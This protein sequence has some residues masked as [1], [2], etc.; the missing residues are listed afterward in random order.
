MRWRVSTSCLIVAVSF[1][2]CGNATAQ[3]I[4]KAQRVSPQEFA[5]LSWGPT[6]AD[7]QQLEW[8][9]DAG[10]NVAGFAQVKDLPVFEKAGL[11]VFVSDKRANG[12]DFEKPLDDA[13]VRRNL[14]SLAKEIGGSPAVLGLMLQDEPHARA[15]PSLGL[16]ARLMREY[17]PGKWPY[18]N[19]FPVRV[20]ADRMGTPTYQ[21]YVRLLV[22][23]IRQPFLSYDN[24][25][26]IGGQMGEAF[27]QNL[28]VVR[29][30]A[31]E[32]GAPL[33]NCVLSNA[34]FNYMENTDATYS[35]QAW[36]TMAH[37]ARGI[38]YFSYFTWSNGNY[39]LGPIDQFG[40][41]TPS[42]DMMRRVNNQIHALAPTLAKLKSTG[43]YHY[44]DVPPDCVALS[45]SRLVKSV[46]MRQRGIVP[47][48][49]GR[50]LIGEFADV[51]GR[52]YLMLVNKDLANS[53]QFR[54]ELKQAGAQLVT[55]SQYS[56]QEVP[57]G[58]EMDW[59]APG[60]GQLLRIKP[61]TDQ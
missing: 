30:L 48:V 10:I 49:Q 51:Q 13:T 4:F 38:Q 36:A 27:Y 20:S 9:K 6:P 34:H 11:Q 7:P 54:I 55:V 18:V 39:R 21:A 24:Y 2:L 15:M 23:T 25:S 52:P 46:E 29:R 31:V 59:V 17:L 14:E 40:N 57:F 5:V 33:W 43:V 44:P 61:G 45:E 53:F 1:V 16:V 12:Y 60:A 8:M 28:E 37:G 32:T 42:W 19:L 41:K 26:L 3:Q 47:P 35:L 50:F 58:R 56:G 22:D